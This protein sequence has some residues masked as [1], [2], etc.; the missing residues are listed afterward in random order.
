MILCRIN[1]KKDFMN[2]LLA[3]DCFHSF[4]L[5]EASICG[6]VPFSIDGRINTSFFSTEDSD[7]AHF[8]ESTLLFFQQRIVILL[9][10]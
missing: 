1:D 5:K 4:L 2:K 6:F 9:I 3:T 7:S 10:F 8:L